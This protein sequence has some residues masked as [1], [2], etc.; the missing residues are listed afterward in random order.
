MSEPVRSKGRILIATTAPREAADLADLLVPEGYRVSTLEAAASLRE[1]AHRER[2]DLICL[3]LGAG[4]LDSLELLQ[5]LSR[6]KAL[7]HLPTLLI[8][9]SEV[10]QD[11]VPL[12]AAGA[13]DLIRKPF[14][15]EEVVARVDTHL[16]LLETRRQLTEVTAQVQQEMALR[17]QA[18]AAVYEAEQSGQSLVDTL[19]EIIYAAD[20]AGTLTYVSSAVERFLGYDPSEV[21][22]RHLSDFVHAQDLNRLRDD[23]RHMLEG[24]PAAGQYRLV[25]KTGEVRW[26]RTSSQPISAGDR[27]FGFQGVLSDITEQRRAAQ[28]IEQQNT[29]LTSVLESLTHPF[30]VINADNYTI[31]I[32]NTAA[33]RGGRAGTATCYSLTHNRSRPCDTSEHPCPLERIRATKQPVTVQHLHYSVTGEL[34]HVEV[35]GYPL[36]DDQGNVSRVIEYA[37]D[38]T[39]RQ[40]AEEALRQREKEYRQ[41]LETLQEGIWVIDQDSVT[42]FVNPRMAEMLGYSV[43]EMLGKHLFSFMDERGVEITKRNLDRRRQGIREQHDFE[44]LRKDGSRMYALMETSPIFDDAGD[45]AGGIAGIQDITGRRRIEEALRKSEALL[46]ETQQM[47]SVGGW[48]LDLEASELFWTEEVY[49]IHQVPPG[50]QPSLETALA[51]YHPEDR[52]MLEAAIQ[53]AISGGQPWDLELRFI[54]AE[55]NALWVRAIGKAERRDGRAVRLSGTFQD[56]TERKRGE[57]ALRESEARWRLVTENSPDHVILLDTNLN[58]Q[59]VNYTSPGLTVSQL[60]GTPLHTYVQAEKQTEIK[61]ILQHVLETGEPASYETEYEAPDAETI[62]YESRVVRRLLDEKVVGLAV[63]ARDITAHKRA[64]RALREATEAAQRAQVAEQA[65]RKEAEQRRRVAESL[66]G[67]LAALNSNKPLDQVLDY[68]AAEARDRLNNQAVA[69][70]QVDSARDSLILHSAQGQM[71]DEML[72]PLFPEVG[73]ALSQTVNSRQP[74]RIDASP[75]DWSTGY[76]THSFQA[77]LATPIIV[78]DEVYG[79][80]LLGRSQ[81]RAFTEEEV[82]LATAFADQIALAVQNARLREQVEQA[83]AAAERN[84]LARDLHDSVTQ[85]LFSASLVAEVLPQVWRRDP[86]EA[87]E[88]VAE[89]RILTRGALAEMRTL[90]LELRPAALV[91]SRLDDLLRQLTEAIASR[92]HLSIAST[93]EPIPALPS[94]VHITFYRVAQE[95]LNNVV[96]HANARQVTLELRASPTL[97]TTEPEN[98]RGQ[99][100]LH[101]KDDGCGFDPNKTAPGQ[102]GLA[103]MHERAESVGALLSLQSQPGHNTQI[104]LVWNRT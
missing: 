21:V 29:F 6:D 99:I 42:T 104:T 4:D 40:Q 55:G 67:A 58:I 90:L 91:E 66:T 37:L 85:A 18:E 87:L 33:R 45:Y 84:R 1:T 25:T 97:N 51:F 14:V 83:A 17:L 23:L 102:L 13:T 75:A 34:R 89:L 64:E 31:E 30:Y 32:A 2:I 57:L 61:H 81:A 46:R 73:G 60:I 65:R 72:A 44:F 12:F 50:Y 74:V 43:D 36:F 92:T 28:Q 48:E 82:S 88:G 53:G 77:L 22:G 10:P 26:V 79:G 62:Y 78:K 8:L 69:V 93:F 35:H 5:E 38:V 98:W 49:R 54:T 59:F 47:A 70:Y 27:I 41:L 63:N 103:I 11:L 16:A 20:E 24:H 96:K 76:T 19:S 52:P 15:K 95:A 39:E 9:D 71:A 56:V 100:V 7:Q 101:I 94:E 3:P 68:I 86:E 80:L